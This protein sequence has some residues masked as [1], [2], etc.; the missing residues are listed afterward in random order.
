MKTLPPARAFRPGV[1]W[2]VIESAE[3]MAF[4]WRV[5]DAN[6]HGLCLRSRLLIDDVSD[7][8]G[9]A[10]ICDSI[11]VTN[12]A[13]LRTV[14]EAAGLEFEPMAFEEQTA[15]LAGREVEVVAKT[16]TPAQGRHAGKSKSVVSSWIVPSTPFEGE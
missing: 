11:D 2:A 5:S 8:L 10:M 16:I 1:Y 7:N 4:Q 13:R 14:F 3:L 6:P 12:I 9:P 15:E